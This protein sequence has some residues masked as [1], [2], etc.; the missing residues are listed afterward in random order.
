VG[1]DGEIYLAWAFNQ[2][3][4][5]DRSYDDGQTWL[6][7]DVIIAQQERGWALDIPGIFRSNGLP[8][9]VCDLSNGPYRGH[10]YVIWTDQEKEGKN[11]DVWISKSDDRGDS[12]S[13]PIRINHDKSKRHQFFPWICIDPITGYLYVVFYDRRNYRDNRTDV[14]LAYSKDG[15]QT[16]IN[17]LISKNPFTP[18]S[19][20]F[21]GDYNHIS[22]YNGIVRPIWTRMDGN[23]LSVWTALIEITDD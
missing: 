7:K 23:R 19:E 2:T 12:W 21:I 22:A 9:T 18:T 4:Y 15:G 10:L 11:S 1:P 5:F 13:K 17:T 3:L 8:V 14:Y 16:F 20:I 6:S